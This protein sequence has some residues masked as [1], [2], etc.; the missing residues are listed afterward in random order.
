MRTVTLLIALG[1]AALALTASAQAKGPSAASVEG[2]GL[3]G[4]IAIEGDGE[5]G[6]T[7]LGNVTEAAGFFPAV[8]AQTPDPMLAE[9]PQGE[10]GPR[11]TITYTVPGPD[12]GVNMIRQ[13]LYPY[14]QD[15][16]VTYMAPGQAV[17]GSERT[18]G[19]WFAASSDL[20]TTLVESGL[21]TSPPAATGTPAATGNNGSVLDGPWPYVVGGFVLAALLAVGIAVVRRR[22]RPAPAS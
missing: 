13:D 2:P 22:P 3:N 9:R 8:F 15:G 20:R 7:A 12:G 14:A 19:G 11:Y 4:A 5:S 6:G 17:F 21:P 18:R 10:L 16:P 1:A